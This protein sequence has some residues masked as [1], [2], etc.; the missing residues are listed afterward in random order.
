MTN[1]SHTGGFSSRP[2][3]QTCVSPRTAVP[4]TPL[5]SALTG[6]GHARPT[7]TIQRWGPPSCTP[8]RRPSPPSPK[9]QRSPFRP[10]GPTLFPTQPRPPPPPNLSPL[11]PASLWLPASP[12]ARGWDAIHPSP[13]PRSS[14]SPFPLCLLCRPA[15]ATTT[16]TLTTTANLSPSRRLPP[17]PP[18]E[19]ALSP[20]LKAP[21]CTRPRTA[22]PVRPARRRRPAPPLEACPGGHASTPSRTA[23]WARHAST[24]G[25]CKV[26]S[27]RSGR[28]E[29]WAGVY[30]LFRSD[31]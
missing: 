28:W 17:T 14:P 2:S 9:C 29:G 1:R 18:P 6:W 24:A 27:R 21:R 22:R 4:P 25:K 16:S 19:G 26:G 31:L 23:S 30:D 13:S 8:A 5:R 11:H 12:T 3:P 20:P 7:P 10:P 15:V